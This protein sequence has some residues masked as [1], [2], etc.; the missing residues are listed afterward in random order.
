M[1][2]ALVHAGFSPSV[3]RLLEDMD[4]YDLYDVLADLAC[5]LMPRT[6]QNRAMAFEFK[7]ED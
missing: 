6:R 5:G 4:D 2:N 3:L 1:L 7:N